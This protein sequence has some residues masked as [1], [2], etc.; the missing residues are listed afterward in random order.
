MINLEKV[1]QIAE[2]EIKQIL[3]R[4]TDL[5][6]YKFEVVDFIRENNWYWFFSAGSEQL[7]KEGYIP[8]EIMVGVDKLDGHIWTES[9][10]DNPAVVIFI[11]PDAGDFVVEEIN[12][13]VA[14]D[15]G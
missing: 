6:K 2:R 15:F 1:K 13:S 10:Y 4:R 7:Q 14:A 8:G 9:E 12:H 5:Q 3:A 11:R